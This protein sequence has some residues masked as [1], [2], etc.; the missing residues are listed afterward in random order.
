M[1]PQTFGNRIAVAL[2]AGL[3]VTGAAFGQTVNYNFDRS[4]DFTKFKTYHWVPIEGAKH[5]DQITDGNITS[6]IDAQL[7]AKGFVKKDA[8]PVDL[9][10]GYGTTVDNEKEIVGFGGGGWRFGGAGMAETQTIQNGT[11]L[12]DIYNP[13][14]K[15]LVWRGT[16][17]EMLDPSSDPNKNYKRLQTALTKLLKDF[18]PPV[19]K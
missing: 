13:T 4:T 5:P 15:L 19:K 1:K 9:F 10:V 8:D 2:V 6:I 17:T 18:P 16:V 12:V 14:G 7:A 3:M 11:I